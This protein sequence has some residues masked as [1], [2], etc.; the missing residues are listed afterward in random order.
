MRVI[1]MLLSAPESSVKELQKRADDR[2]RPEAGKPLDEI[3]TR[4]PE[5]EV[6]LPNAVMA[7]SST[8]RGYGGLPGFSLVE[9]RAIG[10]P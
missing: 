10:R 3:L 9:H 1:G 8:T 6:D 2:L 4:F 7:T 5:W